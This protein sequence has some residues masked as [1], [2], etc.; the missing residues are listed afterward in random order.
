MKKIVVICTANSCRSQMA[1][2]FFRK[3]VSDKYEIFSA[4]IFKS[5]VNSKAI[6]VMKEIGIDISKHTS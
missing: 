3:Y 1:E 6:Q 2:G 4:G 5:Y